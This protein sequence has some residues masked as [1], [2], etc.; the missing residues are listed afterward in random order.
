MEDDVTGTVKIFSKS[1]ALFSA[2]SPCR[3]SG[4]GTILQGLP[5]SKKREYIALHMFVGRSM[6]PIDFKVTRA[7]ILWN[8]HEHADAGVLV[9]IVQEEIVATTDRRRR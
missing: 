6:T 9:L 8:A 7:R 1:A 2:Y 4:S 5:P 3:A